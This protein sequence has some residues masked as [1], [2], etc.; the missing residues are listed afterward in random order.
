MRSTT[1]IIQ[2]YKTL[3]DEGALTSDEYNFLKNAL[4]KQGDRQFEE[5]DDIFV[6]SRQKIRA[7]KKDE[8]RRVLSDLASKAITIAVIAGIIILCIIIFKGC[9]GFISDLGSDTPDY[10]TYYQDDNGNGQL[11]QGE[12]NYTVDEGGNIVDIDDDLSNFE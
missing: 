3:F 11:D 9:V 10:E 8:R 7:K 5:G 4:L 1:G 6:A 12:W 2:E